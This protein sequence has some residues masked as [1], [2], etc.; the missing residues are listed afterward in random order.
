[1]ETRTFRELYEAE[2]D[3]PTAAQA[4]ITRIAKLTKRSEMTVRFWIAGRQ[5]PDELAQSVIAKELD[6]PVEE[7]F[8]KN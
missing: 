4:F 6:V 1:M 5:T 7:L 2:K 3:K 8:P